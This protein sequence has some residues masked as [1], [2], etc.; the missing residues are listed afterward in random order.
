[1]NNNKVYYFAYGSNMSKE[2]LEKRISKVKTMGKAK[3]PN[4]KLVINKE[5]NDGSGKANIVY[6]L[7]NEVWGVFYELEKS[8]LE[9]LDSYEPNYER[10]NVEIVNDLSE[11]LNAITYIST[12]TTD[13]KPFEWY[14]QHILKGAYEH[15]LPNDYTKKLEQIET[16]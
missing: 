6:S 3:L 9:K 16:K 10:I 1:M 15:N 8:K 12:K 13:E 11:S 7:D 2:R 4:Y 14:K 5:G